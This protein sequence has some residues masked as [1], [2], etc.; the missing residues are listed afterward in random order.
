MQGFVKAMAAKKPKTKR[1]VAASYIYALIL[2][3]LVVAQLFTFDEFIRLV[4]S[5]WL[6]GGKPVADLLAGVIVASEV[7]AL[8][9]ILRIN[10]SPLMRIFSMVLSWI[11]PILWFKLSAWLILTVN[12]VSNIGYFGTVFDCSPG[13]DTLL[14]S[15]F[16]MTLS[17]YVSW[18]LWP[19]SLTKSNVK[20]S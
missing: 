1:V 6:P 15:V 9:F 17:G 13:L 8:P 18:G 14:F 12:A 11:V 3:V 5:F 19:D 10:L 16:L 20:K 7:F 2:T 4:E